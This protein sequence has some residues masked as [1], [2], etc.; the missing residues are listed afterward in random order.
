MNAISLFSGIG[1]LDIA[2]SAAGFDIIA[3]VEIDDFC[4]RILKKHAADY[5]PDATQF[6]DVRHFGRASIAGE[7]DCIFGGF[8]CQPHSVAGKQ[9]GEADSRNL[10]PEFA[11]IIGEIRPRSVLLEN[12][13]GIFSTGYAAVVAGDL[14]ALGYDAQWGIV[15][16]ADAGAPHQRERWFCV[17]Y[18]ASSQQWTPGG[19]WGKEDVGTLWELAYAL[20]DGGDAL[21]NPQRQGLAIRVGLGS[22]VFQ[23][24]PPVER[25][26]HL[27]NPQCAGLAS[28][29]DHP[30]CATAPANTIGASNGTGRSWQ[31]A[32][33]RLGGASDGVPGWLDRPRWP[34]G[35]GAQQY[36]YE[37][38][39][40]V[41]KGE[42]KNRANRVKALGNAVV[43]QV[44]YPFA[45]EIM[46]VLTT[47]DK[48]AYHK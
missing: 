38:P 16:A 8:P 25:T 9:Q 11:R 42:D 40:T 4:R 19:K 3:Q 26:S 6:A 10:W 15:S 5:W 36:A 48:A 21:G 46:R 47:H 1:G 14:V 30:S 18:A 13:P 43:P 12:V 41:A 34:A 45:L 31:S 2:F 27:E 32:Q 23:E 28:Q 37:P 24:F 22:H 44:A 7:I 20:Y 29:Q 35:Q 17:A 33:S 39:R